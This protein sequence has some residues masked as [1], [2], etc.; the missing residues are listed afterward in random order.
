MATGTTSDRTGEA[1]VAAVAGESGRLAELVAKNAPGSRGEP[2]NLSGSDPPALR[3]FWRAVGWNDQW[4]RRFRLYHPDADKSARELP[5]LL[6]QLAGESPGSPALAPGGLPKASRLADVDR[7]GIGFVL[8]N[9]DDLQQRDDPPMTIV[10]LDTGETS[11]VPTT[12]LRWCADEVIAIAFSDWF[13]EFVAVVEIP[14]SSAETPFPTLSP[15][16]RILARDVW[17]LPADG[18]APSTA[19]RSVAFASP[20][21]FTAFFKRPPKRPRR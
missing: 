13:Q 10:I 20:E 17:L 4:P 7:D 3:A 11:P 16:T 19:D 6:Q 9:E 21:D 2:V 1:F 5:Q 8:T 14:A 12:Y 15:T 18:Y